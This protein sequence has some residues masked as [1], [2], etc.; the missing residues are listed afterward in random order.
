[1][2]R[3]LQMGSRILVGLMFFVFGLNGFL[4]FIP[5]PPPTENVA[6]FFDGLMSTGYFFPFLKGTEVVCGALLLLGVMPALALVVLAP[7][8]IQIFL[9]HA[10]MTP[11]IQN[12][13]MPVVI[14]ALQVNAARGYWSIYKPL[15][16]RS[17][18]P[19]SG[20]A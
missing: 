9:F 12:L 5:A 19:T 11:G 2:N 18:H 3:K 4:N 6:A 20:L 8:T 15:F 1:M 16:G 10:V 14:I 13:I 7:I 17:G